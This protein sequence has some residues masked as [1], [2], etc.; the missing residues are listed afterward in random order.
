[1]VGAVEHLVAA[2]VQRHH[3]AGQLAVGLAHGVE[4]LAGFVVRVAGDDLGQVAVGHLA[5]GFQ[6]LLQRPGDAAGDAH[7][8]EGG[9][10]QG[11][12]G[13]HQLADQ[14]DVVLPGEVL[15]HAVDVRHGGLVDVGGELVE[16]VDLVLVLA[17]DHVG[18]RRMADLAGLDPRVHGG[19]AVVVG[20]QL[21]ARLLVQ[22]AQLVAGRQLGAFLQ[23]AQQ[24]VV[25]FV[26]AFL[27]RQHC[28]VIGDVDEDVLFQ[29]A[30][31]EGQAADIRGVLQQG[32]VDVEQVVGGVLLGV[33]SVQA[34]AVGGGQQY[35]EA[36]ECDA[37]AGTNF[38]AG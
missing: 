29:A 7:G 1:M 16:L 14:R 25:G 17:E 34:D 23:F 35:D 32:D 19:E 36:A 22:L 38:Q 27:E 26:P 13:K 28:L 37:Q 20:D 31:L 15:I 2:A 8:E 24:L 6:R 10:Q 30:L 21:L 33:Q 4:Q 9:D 3:Q 12:A 5:G 18:D 11:Q